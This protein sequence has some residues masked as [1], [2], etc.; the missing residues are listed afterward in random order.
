MPKGIS[1]SRLIYPPTKSELILVGVKRRAI[2]HSSYVND[3]LFELQP[4]CTFLQLAPDL[5]MFIKPQGESEKD[6]RGE[7]FNF[8]RKHKNSNFIVN[9]LPKY[10]NDITLTKDKVGSLF[11]CTF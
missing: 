5:P 1:F 6:F 9:P 8:V 3:L 10:I 4:E 7:W 11:N 2:L